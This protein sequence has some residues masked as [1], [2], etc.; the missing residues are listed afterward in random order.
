M[1]IVCAVIPRGVSVGGGGGY[2]GGKGEGVS[3]GGGGG[4]W[5]CLWGGG[6]SVG[7]GG[8]GVWCVGGGDGVW[9]VCVWGG[10]GWVC[11]GRVLYGMFMLVVVAWEV[12]VVHCACLCVC[13]CVCVG[14]GGMLV[15]EGM[16]FLCLWLC[17]RKG[18]GVHCLCVWGG[19]HVGY[20]RHRPLIW[21]LWL[22]Q[23]RLSPG[24][25]PVTYPDQTVSPGM[26]PVTHLDQTVS[27]GMTPVIPVRS[28]ALARVPS[29]SVTA[30]SSSWSCRYSYRPDGRDG[31]AARRLTRPPTNHWPPDHRHLRK[32]MNQC[33]FRPPLCTLF[34]LNW[35]KQA[36]ETMR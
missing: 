8:D 27:P 10:G 19:V 6:L 35:T 31:H 30:V 15:C 28:A 4:V 13:V 26:T 29:P 11:L 24:M 36:Q 9:G 16:V 33:C 21:P 34:R 17:V 23:I 22:T 1:Y 32:Q 14:G 12:V 7:G 25:T 18:K 3:V 2:V 5:W 20:L